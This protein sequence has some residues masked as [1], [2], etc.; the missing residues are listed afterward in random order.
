MTKGPANNAPAKVDSRELAKLKVLEGVS[1]ES[2]DGHLARS[3]VRTLEPGDVL[4][5]MGQRS[6]ILYMVLSG[7]LSVH[8]EGGPQAEPV[9]YL[10][11]GE[12]VGEIGLLDARPASAHVVAV[13]RTRVLAVSDTIFWSLVDVSHEFAVNL[14]VLLAQRLR[15]NNSTV[16]TNIRLRRKYKRDATVDALTGLYNRRWLDDML[17]RFVQ[18]FL[19]GSRK[20]VV[21]MAD[22]D[23]FKE[24]NDTNGHPAGDSALAVVAQ[25]LRASVRP[26]DLVA[27]FGGEEFTVILL[28]TDEVGAM[29]AAERLRVTVGAAAIS[30]MNGPLPAITISVG[31]AGLLGE[32][33]AS[34]LIARADAALYRSKQGGRNRVSF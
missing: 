9:A 1:L 27:R 20:L 32:D 22:V 26:T 3:E 7:R 24:F 30:D 13:E 16:S 31:G 8:L 18:R 10:E 21:L 33:T 29:V 23:H 19:R 34:S 12:T 25:T 5:A 2:V 15:S 14:L 28:D 11:A 17:P 6:S 4:L